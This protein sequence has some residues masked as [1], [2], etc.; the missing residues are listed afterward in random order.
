MLVGLLLAT[1]AWSGLSIA[2]SV[3]PDLSWAELNRTLVF[4]AFLAVGLLLG[5]GPRRAC[6]AAPPRRCTVALGA[7]VVWALAGKAIPA[8]FPDGGRAAR[9]RDP[10]GY[11][12]AL[13]LA[14]DVL[15]VL[16]LSFAASARAV[17]VRDGLRCAR[18]RGRRR[19]LPGRLARR[20]RR[21]ACSASRS[22]SGSAATGSRR[23]C[24]R[25]PRSCPQPSSRLGVHPAGARG[26]RRPARRPRRRRG[27]VR[28]AP[29]CR[30][31]ARRG[32]APSSSHGARC[33]LHAPPRRPRCLR[34]F[35]F[36]VGARDGRRRSSPTPAGSR[37]SSAARRSRTI[38]AGSRSLSSN[39][40]LAWWGEARDIFEADPLVG[41]GAN[42]FEV[43]RK[44]YR[45]IASSV[46]QPHSVP[47][48][49]LAGTGLDRAGPPARARRRSGGGGRR[50]HAS[51]RGL[52][53]RRGGGARRCARALARAR[54]RRLRLG[55]RR[56]HRARLLR[57]RRSRSG[58]TACAPRRVPVCCGRRTAALALAAAFSVV[59][60]W[61]AER[62]VRQVNPALERGDLDAARDAAERARSL[63]PLSLE[64]LFARA[65][66]EE[67]ARRRGRRAR[68][69]PA[70]GGAAARQPGR[71]V[72]ARPLR[73][74]PRRPLLGLRAPEPRLH[75][76]PCG[77]AVD[78][79]AASSTRP[80]PG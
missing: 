36:A 23:P 53:T 30:R 57:S 2:W 70:R 20:R 7:G 39:N 68:R 45:E 74:P 12:N 77:A 72:R 26:G 9:L 73:V 31:R 66:V 1:A 79:R 14:A 19:S 40:R 78:S 22:G 5:A 21:R 49:F 50:R 63:N 11:W 8:L 37:T 59:T 13:A 32:S 76:R 62:S 75:A 51:T 67:A 69:L 27:V 34:G 47:L 52:G 3:A 29:G 54:A 33:L 4:A 55:L 44:R 28:A 10:I 41:A 60:P 6:A 42:T 35:A 38:P 61:L 17:S 16:A 24:S 46:T 48:Q 80:A 18:L 56:G 64:P 71:L 65:R 43:A 58:R 25:S 15:L